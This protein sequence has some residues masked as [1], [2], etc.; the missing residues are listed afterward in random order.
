MG[1]AQAIGVLHNR[2]LA[3]METGAAMTER[4]AL[5]AEYAERYCNPHIAAQ[6]GYLD[7]VID[8]VATRTVLAEALAALVDKRDHSIRRRHANGPL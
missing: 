2:R 1:P 3:E 6:R 5:E 7:L 8:P 4:A